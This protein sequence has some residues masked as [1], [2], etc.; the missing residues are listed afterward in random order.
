MRRFRSIVALTLVASC[1]A[2]VV[3]AAGFTWTECAGP[4][5]H[6]V[7][8]N[9]VA[10]SDGTALPARIE[11]FEHVTATA[12]RGGGLAGDQAGADAELSA[13][14]L[15]LWRDENGNGRSDDGDAAANPA[16]WTLLSETHVAC[17]WD[18]QA[19]GLDGGTPG[20]FLVAPVA[21][22]ALQPNKRYLLLLRVI[23]SGTGYTNLMPLNGDGTVVGWGEETWSPTGP[24]AYSVTA[25]GGLSGISDGEVWYF[26]VAAGGE[27][28]PAFPTPPKVIENH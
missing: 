19:Q 17:G 10:C 11:V 5:G 7:S 21:V 2:G 15:W 1:L 18:G 14:Q 24:G 25:R 27:V 3:A 12:H 28:G 9:G 8:V 4:V 6:L 22:P 26:R 13:V 16:G 23:A 20:E